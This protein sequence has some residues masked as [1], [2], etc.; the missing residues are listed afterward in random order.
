VGHCSSWR[1]PKKAPFIRLPFVWLERGAGRKIVRVFFFPEILIMSKDNLAIA[2]LML[3]AMV[4]GASCEQIASEFGLTKSAVS[5]KTRMLANDLQQIVGVVGVDE[6]DS[7]TAALI[8]HHGDAYLE[9][10]EHFVPNAASPWHGH[11]IQLATCRLAQHITKIAR[12]SR[13]VERDS[14]LLLILFAT[15]AKPLE[16]AQLE[17]R[18]YLDEFGE[19]RSHSSVRAEIAVNSRER[20]LLFCDPELTAAMDAYLALRR[21]DRMAIHDRS[22]YRGLHPN[23][24]LFLT[25]TGKPMVVKRTGPGNQHLVCKEIHEIYRRI[26]ALGGHSGINSAMARRLAA[27]R[28]HLEGA[29]KDEIGAAL[30]VKKLAVHKLLHSTDC[31]SRVS[32]T[33]MTRVA[34]RETPPQDSDQIWKSA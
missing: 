28:L 1:T 25:R 30:G 33:N 22:S 26:F 27:H 18:D 2:S 11:V 21:I 6:N 7:P 5:Q 14:A 34:D 17:V 24:R 16:I 9:A 12:H 29:T 8:R 4:A 31:V 20:P 3:R 32:R 15:A 13:C 19:V 10:L 23:S